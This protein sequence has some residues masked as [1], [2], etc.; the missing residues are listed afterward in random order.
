MRLREGVDQFGI[1]F[2]APEAKRFDLSGG[3]LT[4]RYRSKG[5]LEP[6]TID[7]KPEKI[8]PGTI[9]RQ[10]F[11]RLAGTERAGHGHRYRFAS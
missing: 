1:A 9:S 10:I 8:L 5:V 3:I 11:A 7:L 6:I 4:L 2:V